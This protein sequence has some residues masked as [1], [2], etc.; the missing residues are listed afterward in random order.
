MSAMSRSPSAMPGQGPEVRRP[1][2][3][4]EMQRAYNQMRDVEEEWKR[5]GRRLG[6]ALRQRERERQD[7]AGQSPYLEIPMSRR[8]RSRAGSVGSTAPSSTQGSDGGVEDSGRSRKRGHRTH[9]L[10]EPQRLRTAFMRKYVKAC[11]ECHE[12]RVKCTHFDS[13]ELEA[14]YQAYRRSRLSVTLSSSPSLHIPMTPSVPYS[15]VQDPN[16]LLGVGGHTIGCPTQPIINIH[17]QLPDE[18][19]LEL[20]SPTLVNNTRQG[21]LLSSQAAPTSNNQTYNPSYNPQYAVPAPLNSNPLHTPFTTSYPVSPMLS[22]P[23]SSVGDVEKPLGWLTRDLASNRPVWECQRGAIDPWN[24]DLTYSD[25]HKC[26]ARFQSHLSLLDH[27][28]T[29]HELFFNERLLS[30]CGCC[31]S[32]PGPQAQNCTK[33]ANEACGP[34][35]KAS[36]P[37]VLW[38]YGT[39]MP[40]APSLVSGISTIPTGQ[41]FGN[42]LLCTSPSY[43][44]PNAWGSSPNFPN[45]FGTYGGGGSSYAGSTSNQTLA[46]S[47]QPR[48]VSSHHQASSKP[49]FTRPSH[50]LHNPLSSLTTKDEG[51]PSPRPPLGDHKHHNH[52]LPRIPSSPSKGK[53]TTSTTT[54]SL[55]LNST[56]S[57]NF[58]SNLPCL[59]LARYLILLLLLFF[60][61]LG[62]S[63]SS[64]S[65]APENTKKSSTFALSLVL[66][67]GRVIGYYH[68]PLLSVLC[69]ALGV[70]GMCVLRNEGD[71]ID[72]FGEEEVGG[73]DVR[74]RNFSG[75][76]LLA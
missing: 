55:I 74:N 68:M 71:V 32:F 29:Q 16:E 73:E 28:R 63:S 21:L 41:G 25:L 47:S 6:E 37:L 53:R 43:L 66:D 75:I 49:T 60:F 26:E 23:P 8:P 64:S 61:T 70:G 9:G 36:W 35:E 4:E 13:T 18:I 46:A 67:V 1:I 76:P 65:D 40:S 15:P 48:D 7:T 58:L 59:A 12:R 34:C 62:S 20:D 2:L 24:F 50:E 31:G 5:P 14:N 39:M 72:S 69:I 51:L 3:S 10:D 30:R 42:G 57:L 27:Y 19:E 17:E 45:F 44:G 54:F 22:S 11:K 52:Y 33:C 38:Y 56:K